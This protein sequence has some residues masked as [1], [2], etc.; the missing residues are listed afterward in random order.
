LCSMC[1]CIHSAIAFLFFLVN[2]GV[3][4]FIFLVYWNVFGFENKMANMDHK[5]I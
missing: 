4:V 3:K 2:S 1:S 5:F